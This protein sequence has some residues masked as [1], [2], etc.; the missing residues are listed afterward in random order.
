MRTSLPEGSTSVFILCI[1]EKKILKINIKDILR[2]SI[3]NAIFIESSLESL[4]G[5]NPFFADA[6][7][8]VENENSQAYI[9]DGIRK[10][11]EFAY[12]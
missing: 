6:I 9:S 1:E 12:K 11:T 8:D 5:K 2:Y 4:M 7:I 3:A 10:C